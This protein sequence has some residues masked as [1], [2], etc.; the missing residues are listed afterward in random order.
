MRKTSLFVSVFWI[1]ACGTEVNEGPGPVDSGELGEPGDTADA[2]DGSDSSELD[3]ADSDSDSDASEVADPDLVEVEV[4]TVTPPAAGEFDETHVLDVALTM[5]ATDWT[6]LCA[7]RRSLFAL[8]GEG[9]M[10]GPAPDVF[11][12]FSADLELD[13]RV[14]R[15][16][17]VRRK[18]FLGSLDAERPSLRVELDELVNGQKLDGLERLTLNNGKQDP[19]RLRQCL[20]YRLFRAAG[21]PAPRCS[22]AQVRVNRVDLGLYVHVE[23]VKKPFLRQWFG[24]LAGTGDAGDG[25][26]WEGQLSDFRD[27][28]LDTFEAK[29]DT[30]GPA[31]HALLEA[32]VTAL[33]GDDEGLLERLDAVLD[34]DAFLSFWAVESLTAHWDGYAG[35]TNNFFVYAA[36]PG[37]TDRRLRFIPWGVD[38]TFVDPR[39]LGGTRAVFASSALTRRLYLHPEGRRRFEAR[40]REL[41]DSVWDEEALLATI[42]TWTA[43]IRPHREPGSREAG[44]V[45]VSELADFVVTRRDDI[46]GELAAPTAGF[47]PPLRDSLCLAESGTVTATFATTWGTLEIENLFLTGSGTF[48]LES[49]SLPE[50]PVTLVGAKAG[51]SAESQA[52]QLVIG[53]AISGGGFVAAIVDLPSYPE[54]GD[55]ELGVWPQG[56]LFYGAPSGEVV[57]LGLLSGTLTLEAASA[58]GGAEV[59]GRLDASLWT[60]S[61]D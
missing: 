11:T 23:P 14:V 20:A 47:P 4:D 5:A 36:P 10:S 52:G 1:A 58:E 42:E 35:N 27:G 56:T 54:V 33:E 19:S 32:V 12:W 16:V 45:A 28:W 60:G 3:S 17:G 46:E 51:Y 41:L 31:D 22:F 43:L 48:L 8:L 59:R 30:M 53:A 13:G 57:L 18:G 29:H 55:L 38:Q 7:Q 24:D 44:D 49:T 34:L 9:C 39:P 21:V 61:A 2:E 40:L 50:L 25:A 6:A 26:L 15:N 37:S